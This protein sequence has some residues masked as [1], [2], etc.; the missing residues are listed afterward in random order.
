MR[1]GGISR[2]RQRRRRGKGVGSMRNIRFEYTRSTREHLSATQTRVADPASRLNAART[3]KDTG[4]EKI[5]LREKEFV[6]MVMTIIME[7]ERAN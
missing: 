7:T 1:A 3:T 5:L 4:N 2:R 6:A